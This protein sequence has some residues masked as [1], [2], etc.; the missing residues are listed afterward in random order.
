MKNKETRVVD[1]LTKN[2]LDTVR[3]NTKEYH[4]RKSG[5]VK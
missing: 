5:K 3:R 1:R 4:S 2:E